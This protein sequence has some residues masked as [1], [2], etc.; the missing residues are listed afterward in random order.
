[1][2]AYAT[3]AAPTGPSV[4]KRL[5]MAG[6]LVL[7]A[8]AV[9]GLFVLTLT[10][11]ASPESYRTNDQWLIFL[12]SITD[13]AI[14]HLVGRMAGRRGRALARAAL[15]AACGSMALM[16]AGT[17]AAYVV[18]DPG[19]PR[20]AWREQ[21]YRPI[22]GIGYAVAAYVVSRALLELALHLTHSRTRVCR[23]MS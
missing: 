21:N 5:V 15:L 17:L 4:A 19:N 12:A 1:M 8:I 11:M 3:P 23:R 10:M 2:L 20:P 18:T 7:V 6:R 14:C 22:W 9:V 16:S 13:A